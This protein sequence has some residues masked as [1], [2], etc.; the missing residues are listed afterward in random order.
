MKLRL[1][2]AATAALGALALASAASAAVTVS[3]TEKDNLFG[4][5]TFSPVL[6]T[7]QTPLSTYGQVMLDD[8]DGILASEVVFTGN[9]LQGPQGTSTTASPPYDGS[10]LGDTTKYSS[11]QANQTSTF[12]TKYGWALSSFSFFMG[13]PDTFN[14]INFYSKGNLVTTLTGEDIW[15]GLP[16]EANGNRQWGYRIFYDFGGGSIDKITFES[17]GA[18]AFESDGFAGAITGVPE[19]M[20]W[21]LM[22]MGFGGVGA[23]LRSSRRR[24]VAATA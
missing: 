3:G 21:A 6:N 8:F 14:H 18:N 7:Y 23:T 16:G 24:A 12:E 1:F 2:A 9:V 19:P 15:G 13:S 10:A 20:S 4:D 22:I 11:V 5:G 17:T